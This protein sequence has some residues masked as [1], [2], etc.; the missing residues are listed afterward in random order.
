MAV[1]FA[2]APISLFGK[3]ILADMIPYI[4]RERLSHALVV[5]DKGL[6]KAGLVDR[7][8]AVLDRAEIRSTVYSGV[9][10]NPTVDNVRDGLMAYQ[11]EGCDFLIS[12]GGGSPTDCTKAIRVMAGNGGELSDYKGGNKSM[13]KGPFYIAVNTTAGTAS[14]ISRAFLITDPV[15]QEKMIFKDDY[16]MPDIAVDDIE[17]MMNLPAHITAQTGMDALT[18]AVEGYLSVRSSFL[19]EL[20]AK[21]AISMVARHLPCAVL[22]PHSEEARE[23]MVYAQYLAGMS[24]G[25]AGLGLVHAMAHALGA[26]YNL[27]HGLCNA[28]LLPYVLDFYLPSCGDKLAVLGNLM[29]QEET[30]S[31]AMASL[32]IALIRRLSGMAGTKVSLKSLGVREGDFSL[33]AKKAMQDGCIATS[34]VMPDE[35]AVIDIYRKAW[36]GENNDGTC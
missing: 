23:G 4:K 26:V 2:C 35:E 10:A 25:N 6:E 27:P 5:S 17:L 29:A 8:R 34:P 33:L 18:H 11:N 16:A 36:E 32:G 7:L 12:L 14:E 24:F 19:T 13:K 28:V 9:E 30:A 1:E 21:Q 3:G 15:G 31:G 22:N 20:T